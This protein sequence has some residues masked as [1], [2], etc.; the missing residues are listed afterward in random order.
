MTRPL[1]STRIT[2]P[3]S[4]LR[5]VPPLCL[6]SVLSP[7]RGFRLDFSLDIEATGSKVPQMS[8]IRAL[9]VFVPDA[10]RAGLQAPPTLIPGQPQ[11]PGFDI[12][13]ILFRHVIDGSL[14]FDF[15]D[16]T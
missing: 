15:T 16:R 7:L 8:L 5:V 9:A 11:L 1:R 14:A 2:R 6:A 10:T 13:W 4:L 12:V 3:S